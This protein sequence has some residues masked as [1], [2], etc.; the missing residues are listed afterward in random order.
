MTAQSK[1]NLSER[2]FKIRF[3]PKT[4]DLIDDKVAESG[5]DVTALVR[6]S[7]ERELSRSGQ[8]SVEKE[9]LPISA[10][11]I[12][13]AICGSFDEVLA[14]SET[15]YNVSADIAKELDLHAGDVFVRA[16]GD[17]MT[18]VGI[19]DGSLV[20][21]EI[22]PAGR[23]PR[24]GEIALVQIERPNGDY[25]SCLKR[26]TTKGGVVV[27]LD[28]DDKAIELPSDMISMKAIGVAR[29]FIARV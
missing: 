27:L 13:S 23:N 15:S 26:W 20:T 9:L 5:I 3:Y 29:S 19:S 4:W 25:E 16:R 11:V 1:T 7:V 12:G 14:D 6:Q 8:T 28:G 22:L 17:S 24:N 18:G 10:P 2:S 21:L